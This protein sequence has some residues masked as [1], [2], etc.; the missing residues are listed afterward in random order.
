MADLIAQGKSPR[1]RWRRRLPQG[2]SVTLGRGPGAFA[3]DWDEWISRQHAEICWRGGV[4]HVRKLP[5]ARNPI[6]VQG[7]E[8]ESFQIRP[9]EHFVVGETSFTL[10]DDR[11]N[12]APGA[13]P[14]VRE[15]TFS[16]Q[17]LQQLQYRNAQARIDMLGR[18]PEVI[19]GAASD[20]ELIVRMI[21][22]LLAGIPTA[23]A[24]ALVRVE[25]DGREQPIEVL[26]WDRH[27]IAAGDFQPSEHLIREAVSRRESVLHLWSEG[28]EAPFTAHEGIDWAFCTPVLGEACPGWAVYVA[29][30]VSR[31][32]TDETPSTDPTDL[33][34]DLK[35]TE[36]AAATLA[37]LRQVR[38]L[39]RRHAGLSQFFSP[40]VLDALADEDPS[41]VLAP[42]ETEVTVLFCDLRGFARESEKSAGDL[43]GL[44]KR[45]SQ[46][47]GVTTHQILE[48][49]GVVGDFQGDA[50]MGFWGWPLAQED[51]AVRACRAALAI[52]KELEAASQRRGDL[53]DFQMGLG[54]AT[55]QA[56]AGKIGTVDQVKVTVFGPVVNLASRLEGMTKIVRAP[57]L[58]DEATAS[59]VRSQTAANEMRCRR[60]AV[61]R[62]AGMESAVEVNELLPGE[63]D[64]PALTGEH[65]AAYEAALDAFQ[66]G[67]W[68]GAF[69]LLHRVPAEDRAKDFL[70]GYIAQH[71]RTPPADWQGF[72]RL[73]SKS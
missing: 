56:V 31:R 54:I 21:N 2:E 40:I 69:E 53:A 8:Q 45:V 24:V 41:V 60:L 17:Y 28:S 55:G 37:S 12:V 32:P 36:V 38:Q 29:G 25:L 13:R 47:L 6:F 58:L 51:A 4:L 1:H 16:A 52:R 10:A 68:S 22:M 23:G 27:L 63:R 33:R 15:Q 70:T 49:G 19:L 48:H 67:D 20:T 9:G 61:V 26:H 44:L 57:I 65:L 43:M 35:F 46:A 64:F 66:S 62:P 30:S 71:H 39:E 59:R 34:D 72:I 5:A 7:N 18:M 11:V 42:R 50:A 3:A 14:P 73:A